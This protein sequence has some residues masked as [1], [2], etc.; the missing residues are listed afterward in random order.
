MKSKQHVQLPN[1]MEVEA[2][3]R[4]VYLVIKSYNNKE[5]GCFP[6]LD[7]IAK[8]SKLSV[9]TIRKSIKRLESN[10]YIKVTKIGRKNY[11]EFSPYKKWEPFSPEFLKRSDLTPTTKSYLIAIQQYMYKDV[12]GVGKISFSNMEL[13]RQ[14]GI[15]EATIRKCNNE[16]KRNNF[17]TV[18]KNTNRDLESGSDTKLFNMSKLDQ[19]II[20][21][22]INHEERIQENTDSIKRL[23]KTIQEQQKLIDK[24]LKERQVED[25]KFEM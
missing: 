11:Y 24:L 14:T 9:P 18:I 12:E 25:V 6:S 21:G 7:T 15:P 4:L 5:L 1:D 2:Q 16:L 8:D 10:E 13:S 20:W 17:M 3:D 22:L 23:E 19:A